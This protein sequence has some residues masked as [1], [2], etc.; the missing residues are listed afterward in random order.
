MEHYRKSHRLRDEISG[1]VEKAAFNGFARL[2]RRQVHSFEAE[3][4]LSDGAQKQNLIVKGCARYACE[5]NH[6]AQLRIFPAVCVKQFVLLR[7]PLR[8]GSFGNL[9]YLRKVRNCLELPGQN[10][11]P[12]GGLLFI[13]SVLRPWLD[14]HQAVGLE[15]RDLQ[16]E[17]SNAQYAQTFLCI[18]I[19]PLAVD[20]FIEHADAC[21][22]IVA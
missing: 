9:D 21:I 12:A 20:E 3:F 8:E 18:Q 13:E 14:S 7:P 10:F 11:Q 2:S 22:R 4:I 16:H 6:G 19:H 5:L 15:A 17:A 1:A